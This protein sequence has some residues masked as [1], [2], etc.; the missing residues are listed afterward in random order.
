MISL[1]EFAKLAGGT[2]QGITPQMQITGFATD[3]RLAETLLWMVNLFGA[4]IAVMR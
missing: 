1:L 3:P 2:P 4:G